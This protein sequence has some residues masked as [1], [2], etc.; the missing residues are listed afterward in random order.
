MATMSRLI[1]GQSLPWSCWENEWKMWSVTRVPFLGTFG[2]WRKMDDLCRFWTTEALAKLQLWFDVTDILC[3]CKEVVRDTHLFLLSVL[4]QTLRQTDFWSQIEP[5]LYSKVLL[6]VAMTWKWVSALSRMPKFPQ[7]FEIGWW[8]MLKFL[9]S[10]S[11]T[12]LVTFI[13]V[14]P[15][16]ALAGWQCGNIQQL[17]LRKKHAVS[18][19]NL[20]V[21]KIKQLNSN[22]DDHGP[23]NQKSRLAQIKMIHE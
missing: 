8:W 17:S 23:E 14:V 6:N 12:N 5:L 18:P 19:T 7:I 2:L 15:A 1:I 11:P 20:V 9:L 21:S 10:P 13:L 4:H 16:C 22:E 3:S